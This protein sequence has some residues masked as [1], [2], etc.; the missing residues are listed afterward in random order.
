MISTVRKVISI[1]TVITTLII[2]VRELRLAID[3]IRSKPKSA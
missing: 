2:A 3:T 1:I